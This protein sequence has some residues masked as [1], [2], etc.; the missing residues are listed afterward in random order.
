MV[1]KASSADKSPSR[2]IVYEF[3]TERGETIRKQQTFGVDRF[4]RLAVGGPIEVTYARSRPSLVKLGRF[5]G[6]R[7]SVVERERGWI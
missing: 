2:T 3:K 1:A 6:G 4:N 5:E 7:R